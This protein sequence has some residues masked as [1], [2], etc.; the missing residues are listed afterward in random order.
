MPRKKKERSIYIT[1]EPEWNKH[2]L[3]TDIEEQQTAFHSCEYFVRTEIPKKKLVASVRN[4]VKSTSGWSKVICLKEK[5]NGLHV[6][7]KFY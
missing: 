7:K 1:K 5:M 3:L 4:W 6:V 2:R